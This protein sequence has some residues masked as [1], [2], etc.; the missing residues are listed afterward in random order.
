MNES[1]KEKVIARIHTHIQRATEQK[2]PKQV[3]YWA[4]IL[5]KAERKPANFYQEIER[6]AKAASKATGA[7]F[8]RI[9]Q[10]GSKREMVDA[11]KFVYAY[12]GMRP[13]MK[14][15]YALTVVFGQDHSTIYKNVWAHQD[16][17]DV[18]EDYAEKFNN[19]LCNLSD[20]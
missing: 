13:S 5:V 1:Y 4:K 9:C 2:T 8:D 3:S 14:S 11:R 15:E 17:L 10:K 16:T 7:D 19:F 20:D 6:L 18:C 12:V